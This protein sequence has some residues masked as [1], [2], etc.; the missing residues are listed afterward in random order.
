LKESEIVMNSIDDEIAWLQTQLT[1]ARWHLDA[2]VSAPIEM[3]RR[4][5]DRARQA[6]EGARQALRELGLTGERYEAFSK[7]LTFIRERL[8]A[9]GAEV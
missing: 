9:A 6:Y 1:V 4:N 5:I 8:Q 2:A 3:A 7:E